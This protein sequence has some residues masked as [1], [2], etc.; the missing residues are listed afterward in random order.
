VEDQFILTWYAEVGRQSDGEKRRQIGD[1]C[2]E[3]REACKDQGK[4][5]GV[6]Q[7]TTF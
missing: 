3:T 6:R 7:K 2:E 5:S 1:G 4:S